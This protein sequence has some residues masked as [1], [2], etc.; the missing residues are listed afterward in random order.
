M[1]IQLI[2][3]STVLFEV[4]GLRVLTDPFFSLRGNPAYRRV[5]PPALAREE[6]LDVDVVLV[7]HNHWDHTDRRFFR[8]L[9]GAVPVLAPRRARWVTALK[10]ARNVVGMSP[11][12]SWQIATLKITAV[13]AL[14]TAATV[15]FVLEAQSESAYFAGDTY[16]RPFMAEIGERFHLNLALLPVTTYRIP[17]TMGERGALEAVR[18]L[19]APEII[20]IHLGLQPRSPLLRTAQSPERFAQA[21]A[22]EGLSCRVTILGPGERWSSEA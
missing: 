3:H 19:R 22:A 9:S 20:P 11:W 18:D 7:S 17:M 13:P 1:R 16:H 10:G 21:V 15:G 4:A 6:V 2:G 12:E 8:K 14:H 5:T